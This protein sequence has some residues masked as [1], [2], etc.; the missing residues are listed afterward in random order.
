MI[1]F[2]RFSSDCRLHSIHDEDADLLKK[3]VLLPSDPIVRTTT[4][5]KKMKENR[6]TTADSYPAARLHVFAVSKVGVAPKSRRGIQ[7]FLSYENVLIVI[8]S[9]NL[10]TCVPHLKLEHLHT[11]R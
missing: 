5:K 1:F 2:T 8:A 9:A 3:C 7:V 4:W 11:H 6:M 10:I